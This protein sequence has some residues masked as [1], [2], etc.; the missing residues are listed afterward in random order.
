MSNDNISDL[1][2]GQLGPVT[3]DYLNRLKRL[4]ER[5]A[6]TTYGSGLAVHDYGPAR[7]VSADTIPDRLVVT[8]A[9]IPPWFHPTEEELVDESRPVVPNGLEWLAAGAENNAID[10]RWQD[11]Q[12]TFLVHNPYPA[13]IQPGTVLRIA[14]DR[15]AGCWLPAAPPGVTLVRVQGYPASTVQRYQV[16]RFSLL[17]S[18]TSALQDSTRG[19]G[20]KTVPQNCWVLDPNRPGAVAPG[21]Y[22]ASVI[23][24]TEPVEISAT[25]SI[26]AGANQ[27]LTVPAGLL[28]DSDGDL[29]A[30]GLTDYL[31]PG[32]QVVVTDAADANKSELALILMV[33]LDP[34][35]DVTSFVLAVVQSSYSAPKVLIPGKPVLA[36]ANF[37]PG[38]LVRV[39]SLTKDG[40]NK[41]PGFLSSYSGIT[42]GYLDGDTVQV[43]DPNA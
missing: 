36:P 24:L 31:I 39:T 33:T 35:T 11:G 37:S 27:T 21:I 9:A 20:T 17:P 28:Y 15:A 18:G 5:G 2:G 4:A 13:V 14:W 7:V 40:D 25:G 3:S 10:Y 38:C 6:K 41:Q 29:L 43:R 19:V 30:G 26:S 1:P 12:D 22:T 23:D 32:D 34:D 8:T 42:D 16:G